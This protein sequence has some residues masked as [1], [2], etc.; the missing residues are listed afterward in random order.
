MTRK[1][2][3]SVPDDVA[4]R[5]DREANVSAFVT[6]A[7]RVRMAAENVRADMKAAGFRLTDEDLTDVRDEL[8]ALHATVTPELRREAD[9]IRVRMGRGQP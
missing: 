2:A 7:V 8:N 4:A 9:E 1:L 5:L 3:I 6:D